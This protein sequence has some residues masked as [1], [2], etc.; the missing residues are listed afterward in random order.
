MNQPA[1][2]IGLQRF[3]RAIQ[4]RRG[5]P[6]LLMSPTLV[7][8]A[9]PGLFPFSYAIRIAA[10]NISISKPYLPVLSVGLSQYKNLVRDAKFINALRV[11]IIFT[12]EAV[13]VQVWLSL[14]IAMPFRRRIVAKSFFRVCIL[15]PMVIAPVAV[16]LM[17]RILLSSRGGGDV[18]C[19]ASTFRP[20]P[21]RV[22]LP[23]RRASILRSSIPKPKT[24]KPWESH[25]GLCTCMPTE[26]EMP[27]G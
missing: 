1:E 21:A 23:L 3:K 9:F 24:H 8:L 4:S 26:S 22:S 12:V 13:F 27:P 15:V 25:G 17:W 2:A 10:F 11:T 14:G 5:F 19:R 6:W 18:L 20:G 7:V 16:G